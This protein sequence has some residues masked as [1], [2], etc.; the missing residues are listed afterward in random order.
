MRRR[1]MDS[2]NFNFSSAKN[3][4]FW[5]FFYFLIFKFF[6]FNSRHFKLYVS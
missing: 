2:I 3:Y 4:Y 1:I 5:P 6:A